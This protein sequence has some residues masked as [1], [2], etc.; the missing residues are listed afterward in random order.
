[1]KRR[2]FIALL[3]GAAAA[4]LAWPR[5]RA[6]QRRRRKFRASASS[7]TARSGHRSGRRCARA[8]YIDGQTIAFEYRA[9]RRQSGAARRRRRPNWRGCPVDVIATY[10]TPAEPRRQGRHI[11][12]PDRHDFGRRSGAGRP[13]A[14]PRA[15]GR[16]RH[17]QH[18]SVAGPGPKR[19]Q[20]IKEIILRRRRALPALE[21]RQR[22]QR[23][24]PRTDAQPRP[25]L[26]LTFTAVEARSAD[27][28]DG[29]F[30]ILAR[31]RPDRGAAHQR[32]RTPEPHPRRSSHFCG[33]QRGCRRCSRPGTTSRPAG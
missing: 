16:Q 18:H 10:G 22:L 27:D 32:S 6:Q 15:S 17:R 20:L 21:S 31:E 3:G 5:R 1:M 29:A 30:A 14:K 7:T 24:D 23:G 33:T 2:E 4:P 28:L 26:G 19:L 8:G 12:D 25:A 9:A 13:G 11:D